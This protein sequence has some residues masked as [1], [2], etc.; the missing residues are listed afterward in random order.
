MWEIIKKAFKIKEVDISKKPIPCVSCGACCAYFRVNFNTK[1]NPQV[2]QEMVVFYD[3]KQM[4]MK[5][6]EKFKGRCVALDGEIGVNAKCSIYEKRPNLCALFPVWLPNG[7]Q[8]PRCAK[9]RK[10]HGLPPNIE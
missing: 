2:P 1:I 3:R 8:N 7:K 10:F 9:A 6:A 4:A 5:G